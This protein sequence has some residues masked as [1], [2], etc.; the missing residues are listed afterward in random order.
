MGYV[1]KYQQLLEE[2]KTTIKPDAG[3]SFTLKDDISQNWVSCRI[4]SSVGCVLF[5]I[6]SD[7][8]KL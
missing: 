5:Y 7:T 4:N 8:T 1:N 6:R 3:D 2:L